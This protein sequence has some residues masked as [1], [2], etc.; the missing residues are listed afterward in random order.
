MTGALCTYGCYFVRPV[1]RERAVL[2]IADDFRRGLCEHFWR[3]HQRI[4][5]FCNENFP[6]LWQAMTEWTGKACHVRRRLSSSEQP[7]V[8]DVCDLRGTDEGRRRFSRVKPF[9][10]VA[11][12]RLAYEEL[13]GR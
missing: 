11:A 9:L 8:G 12:V 3:A 2:A 4:V 1:T 7:L 6:A 5:D 13:E 10:P